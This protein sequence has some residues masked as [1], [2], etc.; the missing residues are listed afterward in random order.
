MAQVAESDKGP[1]INN[2]ESICSS[3]NFLWYSEN[4][5]GKRREDGR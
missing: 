1:V 2:E 4:K 3:R 5:T